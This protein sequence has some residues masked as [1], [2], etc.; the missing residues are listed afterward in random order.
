MAKTEFNSNEEERREELVGRILNEFLDRRS[1]GEPADEQALLARYPELADALREDLEVLRDLYPAS[2][3][4]ESLIAQGILKRSDKPG[5]LA[6]LEEYRIRA[7]V[8]RGGM[9][10]VLKADDES[11]GRTVAV[12]ILRPDMADDQAALARFAR[13]AKTAAALRHPNIVGVHRVGQVRGVPF[14]VMEYVAGRSV[15]DLVRARGALPAAFCRV[16]FA[17]LLNGLQAAHE[18]DLVHRDVKSSNI[19]VAMDGAPEKTLPD[20]PVIKIADFGLARM[21]TSQTQLTVADAVVGTPEYMSPEQARGESDRIDQRAD[22]YSA[23]VVLYEMLAGHTPFRTDTP[24]ATIHR[25]LNE[26]PTPPALDDEADANLSRLA[27]RLMAKL[28][29]NR[30][31]SAREVLDLLDANA[32]VG[33]PEHRRRWWRR[34]GVVVA[35]GIALIAATSL[36]NV[37][38]AAPGLSARAAGSDVP[39]A[40]WVDEFERNVVLARY[41]HEAPPEVFCELTP[42]QADYTSAV[43]ARPVAAD[44][45][46]V[47]VGTSRSVQDHCVF[48]YDGRGR[49]LWRL[50]LSSEVSW[51]DCAPPTNWRCADLLAAD[52]DGLPGEEL[53]VMASDAYEYPTR[54]SLVDARTAE[55]GDTFW[56]MGHLS[57]MELAPDY[58]GAGHPALLLWGVNN[59]LDGFYRPVPQDAAP[60]TRYDFVPVVAVL[61][62]RDMAGLAPPATW[63][64]KEIPPARPY[65]YALLD[66]PPSDMGTYVP[67]SGGPPVKPPAADCVSIESVMIGDYPV[68][69]ATGPWLVVGLVR[70]SSLPNPGSLVV[71]RQLNYV[72]VMAATAETVQQPEGAWQRYWK[73]IVQREDEVSAA[74]N[75]QARRP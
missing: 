13:E 2:G 38:G 59:K 69:D 24:T 26:P 63:R 1:R 75:R 61:D 37:G 45:P 16:V 70:P 3:R 39:T 7:V 31:R 27:L 34:A 64:I 52:V 8:G 51:P 21:R 74:D 71:D 42:G 12:K 35:A 23:G 66:R 30:F 25:I 9:G 65:A 44:D 53:V 58:F 18:A 40:V 60:H 55:I 67:A 22:L 68:R 4:I 62:P 28:P 11:L 20:N 6:E 73:P 54:V 5:C 48:A 33:L 36:W 15:A 10:I 19:I 57:G 14:I 56:H 49:E 41:G 29:E 17:Q 47:V 43:L 50:N 72:Q 46:I 32:P